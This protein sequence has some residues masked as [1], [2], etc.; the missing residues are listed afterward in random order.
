MA[1]YHQI[2]ISDIHKYCKNDFGINYQIQFKTETQ[3]EKLNIEKNNLFDDNENFKKYYENFDEKTIEGFYLND[4]YYKIC[5]KHVCNNTIYNSISS[6]S[7]YEYCKIDTVEFYSQNSDSKCIKMFGCENIMREYIKRLLNIPNLKVYVLLSSNSLIEYSCNFPV[8]TWNYGCLFIKYYK[9][10]I[11][12][13]YN[14]FTHNK[15]FEGYTTNFKNS[16]FHQCSLNYHLDTVQIETYY[17]DD[18]EYWEGTKTLSQYDVTLLESNKQEYDS[19]VSVLQEQL[20]SKNDEIVRIN[21]INE[22]QIEKLK[23]DYDLKFKAETKK[24]KEIYDETIKQISKNKEIKKDEPEI[25]K[26]DND[27]NKIIETLKTQLIEL[28]TEN[29]TLIETNDKLFTKLSKI[30]NENKN[31]QDNNE[32]LNKENI[33]LKQK[34]KK[35]KDMINK[36]IEGDLESHESD[37]ES[38]KKY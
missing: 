17:Q 27:D 18:D 23:K 13:F 33:A 8:S 34:L 36:Y 21:K 15:L 20:K 24:L 28:R 6:N 37:N 1:N 31:L 9:N 32:K 29:Q 12:R 22:E 4:K 16:Y 38:D 30:K 5:K 19:I 3:N 2:I 35:S 11:S 7:C 10:N 25:N 26:Q 14:L